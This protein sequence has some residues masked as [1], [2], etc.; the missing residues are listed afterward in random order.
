MMNKYRRWLHG[1]EL[2]FVIAVV[3]AVVVAIV[4]IASGGSGSSGTT[5]SSVAAGSSAPAGSSVTTSAASTSTSTVPQATV[6]T[7]GT[8]LV[9]IAGQVRQVL[10]NGDFVVNDGKVDYTV[11]MSST[12]KVVDLNGAAAS[13]DGIQVDG[14]AQVSGLL[15]GTTIAAETVMIPTPAIDVPATT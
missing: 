2:V 5:G 14:S 6:T 7:A 3:V 8:I 11:A 12:T 10:A 13:P 1:R 9:T 15:S 4:L